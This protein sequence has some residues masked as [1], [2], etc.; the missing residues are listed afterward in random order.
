MNSSITTLKQNQIPE[1]AA[2][3]TPENPWPVHIISQKFHDAVTKWPEAWIEG[4]VTEINL[5]RSSSGY[6]TL[7]DNNQDV[8]ISVM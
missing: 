4:Q 8:S 2:L 3:T 1:R 7:R 5:R 6:I